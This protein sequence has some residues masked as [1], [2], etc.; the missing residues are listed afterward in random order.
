MDQ[1]LNAIILS[2][3][4]R[5]GLKEAFAWSVRQRGGEPGDVHAWKTMHE[6]LKIIAERL[7]KTYILHQNALNVISAFDSPTTLFYC[8]PPYVP[9]TRVS[10]NVY[11]EN[12]MSTDDHIALANLLLKSKGKIIISG[13]PCTLYNRLYKQWRCT[14]KTIANHSSQQKIK[15]KKIEACW[16]NF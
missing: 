8:D 10:P 7:K 4:S 3:M 15:Q 11:G 2:R 1:A 5:G 9:D 6:Q 16:M 14:T 12:E 13:Y